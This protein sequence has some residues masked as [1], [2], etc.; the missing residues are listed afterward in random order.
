MK[1]VYNLLETIEQDKEV[2]AKLEKQLHH[3]ESV[4]E[5]HTAALTR[6]TTIPNLLQPE[7]KKVDCSP[8]VKTRERI[9]QEN[10][11][12][13]GMREGDKVKIVVTGDEDFEQGVVYLISAI[14]DIHY[15]DKA[16]LKLGKHDWYFYNCDE[17]YN[18]KLYLIRTEEGSLND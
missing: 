16:F 8:A 4:L 14:E 3:A 17:K 9:T 15:E 7:V 10:W 5:A 13:L 6:L 12:Q 18:D 11:K 1:Q 2:V